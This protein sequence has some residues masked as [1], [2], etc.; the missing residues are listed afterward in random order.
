LS[1]EQ[2][3]AA[4]QK[5]RREYVEVIEDMRQAG[6]DHAA[7][8]RPE[9]V[10]APEVVQH[11]AADELFLEYLITDS[12]V[13]VFGITADGLESMELPET[14][15]TL[16]DLIGFTR[17]VLADAARDSG[18]ELWRVPLKRLHSILIEPVQAAGWLEGREHLTVVPHGELHYLPFQAL[19]NEEDS[20][21]VQR[22]SI[23]YAPSATVW[24]QLGARPSRVSGGGV[25]AMA[26]RA[27]ELPA[28][29]QEMARI[30]DAYGD[31]A[32]ILMGAEATEEALVSTAGTYDVIHLATYG[33]LN[34]TNPL[35]SY[36]ELRAGTTGDGRLEAHELFGMQL[37]ADL[38]VLS[39][40]ETGLASGSRADVPP[41]D[42]WVG[43]VRSFLS[44]GAS[45]VVATLWRVE[46]RATA[47]LMSRFYQDLASG[48][49]ARSALAAAQ[50]EML[51]D[52]ATASPFYWAG[53]VLVGNSGGSP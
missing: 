6:V 10:S 49:P 11:L 51:D 44:A 29:R 2:A 35:F 26:P 12:S 20:F 19:L 48:E 17:G 8:V 28:T 22:Y 24:A 46:D 3:T 33:V 36:V 21:L 40:C 25:L 47:D 45:E 52:P 41:G 16:E 27:A 14:R 39:A 42:D 30:R 1:A 7:L 53:F 32:T 5:A 34:R 9:L 50:R 43:L 4:L 37:D 13:L 31:R 15:E 38:V 18:S 23:S